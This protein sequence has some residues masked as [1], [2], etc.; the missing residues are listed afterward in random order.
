MCIFV[1]TQYI[2]ELKNLELTLSKNEQPKKKTERTSC[3]QTKLQYATS[4]L[5]REREREREQ[6]VVVTTSDLVEFWKR[7]ACIAQS[8]HLKS[9]CDW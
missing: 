8:I 9:A 7:G 4:Q 1:C 2:Y 6:S 5:E 3:H